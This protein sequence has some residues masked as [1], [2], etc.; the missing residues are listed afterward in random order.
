VKLARYNEGRLGVVRDGSIYDVTELAQRIVAANPVRHGDGVIANLD[1]IR[2]AID[3]AS[4]DRPACSVNDAVLLSPVQYPTKLIAAPVNYQA[5]IDEAE[6]DKGITFNH[7][8]ARID[9]AGLFLKANSSLVGPGEGI[10][11]RFPDRRTDHEVEVALVIGRTCTGTTREEALSYVAGYAIGLD[12]SIR[13]TEDR[14][15][16]KSIDSYSVLGPWLVTADEIS[17]P[18]NLDLRIRNNGE[19]KQD[20]NTRY[21]LRDIEHLIV[22]AAEWYTLHPG[23]VIYTGTPEGVAP[24]KAGDVLDCEVEKVGTMRVAVRSH[25]PSGT[26][27]VVR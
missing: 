11:V 9:Q 20:S 2:K 4:L 14:S 1:A 12:M 6:A 16:R 8:V 13:G 25:V 10:A 26:A 27:T 18:G 21:L 3:A 22:W 15:M 5:H 23:D 17:D 24:V 7:A 19:I